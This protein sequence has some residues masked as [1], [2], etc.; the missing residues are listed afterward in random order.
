M[1]LNHSRAGACALLLLALLSAV[2]AQLTAP[3]AADDH[4]SVDGNKF[5]MNHAELDHA[6]PGM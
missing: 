5:L 4:V 6:P 3:I 1:V 2:D